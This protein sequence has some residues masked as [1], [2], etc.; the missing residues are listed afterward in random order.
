MPDRFVIR[1]RE[2]EA[3]TEVY[4]EDLGSCIH[5]CVESDGKKYV[6][7]SLQQDG[8][9]KLHPGIFT[10]NRLGIQTTDGHITIAH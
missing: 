5:M 1:D 6:I 4:L 8:R 9:L 2:R 10:D 7:A 3:T